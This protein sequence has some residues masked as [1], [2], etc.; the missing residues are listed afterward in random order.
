M[1][2]A[3]IRRLRGWRARLRALPHG[4]W[5]ALSTSV[6]LGRNAVLDLGPRSTIRSYGSI[7]L[8]EGAR[9]ELGTGSAIM[10]GAE[11][12]VTKGAT[13]RVGSETYIGAYCNLRCVGSIEIEDN[14][15]LAQFVSVVDANYDFRRRSVPIGESIP[16]SVKVRRGAWIGAQ[17]IVL[18]GVEI[19]EGAVVGAGSVVTKG[20]AAFAIVAGN[21][22][23]VLGYRS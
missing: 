22:A 3:I 16:E 2:R 10:Q 7:Y 4:G 19:G 21:P 14:V 17:A 5:I 11:I 8:E 18:P 13:L 23:R 12:V 9:L 15:R 1:I 6:A 20:V